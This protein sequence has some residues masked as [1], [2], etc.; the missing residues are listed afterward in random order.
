MRHSFRE[1]HLFSILN[2]FAPR[3]LPLDVYMSQYFRAHTAV[4]SKDRKWIS[5]TVYGMTRWRGLLDYFCVD[6]PSWEKRYQLYLQMHTLNT[7]ALPPHIRVSFPKIYFQQL[8]K[9]YG[10]K[11]AS[12]LCL[13]SN[14][15]APVTLRVNTLKISREELFQK[16]K[17]QYSISYCP[18]SDVGLVFQHKLNFFA[19]EEFKNGLFEIQDEGSQR[20]AALVGAK[21]GDHIL[22]YCAGSGGKTLA[23]APATQGK[24]QIYLHDIR[25]QALEEA[26]KR[27]KRAGVQ[28]A[29]IFYPD[30]PKTSLLKKKMDWVLVDA[31]CSGSGTLRRNPDMKW[32]FELEMIPRLASEQREIFKKALEFLKDDGKIVYATCSVFPEENQDQ[33]RYFQETFN[34]SLAGDL[35]FTFPQSKGMDGFFG[36]ILKKN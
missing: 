24:G 31:P 21:P 20:V 6:T 33:I 36:A 28:N 4:G 2:S 25:R 26:K 27:L 29:Q 16:W 3:G 19:M 18:T 7:E 22:D 9:H 34:L 17:D 10:E 12:S 32:K 13:V 11:I 1:H 5:D 23:F 35:F 14:E 30:D 15:Q 8:E